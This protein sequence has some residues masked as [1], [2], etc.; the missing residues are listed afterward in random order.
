[1]SVH[2]YTDG[3][4]KSNPDGAAAY[5]CWINVHGRESWGVGV[6]LGD[7][8]VTNNEAE[9]R[10]VLCGLK[11]ALEALEADDVRDGVLYADSQLAVKQIAGEYAC[12]HDHLIALRDEARALLARATK[13][14]RIEHVLRKSNKLAD[15][16][17][18]AAIDKR[19]SVSTGKSAICATQLPAKRRRV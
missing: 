12:N 1:M 6:F 17:A 7:G 4:V 11:L 18:N 9:Y 13:P 14:L 2:V 15:E 8:T 10:G 5:G 16:M 3:A 19:A